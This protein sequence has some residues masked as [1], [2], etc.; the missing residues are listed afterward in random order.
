MNLFVVVS[1]TS[2]Q[3]SIDQRG[4]WIDKGRGGMGVGE[5]RK[6]GLIHVERLG[7]AKASGRG[8]GCRKREG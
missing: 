8:E 4:E 3:C 1:E 5:W 7:E 6:Q 2:R